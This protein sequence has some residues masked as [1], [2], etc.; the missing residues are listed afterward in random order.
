[1]IPIQQ[2]R[3]GKGGN[4]FQACVAS[5]LEMP[6]SDVPDFCNL[7]PKDWFLQFGSWLKPRGMSA[8]MIKYDDKADLAEVLKDQYVLA[9]GKS[10]VRDI[11]HE[12]VWMNGEVM[13]DPAPEQKGLEGRPDD[14]IVITI[15]NP[16]PIN[17]IHGLQKWVDTHHSDSSHIFFNPHYDT[18]KFLQKEIRRLHTLIEEISK[19]L[20]LTT[21]EESEHGHEDRDP[22]SDREAPADSGGR[23]TEGASQESGG[24]RAED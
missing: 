2:T 16:A 12:V 8:I 14:F 23:S 6:L 10:A 5:L 7:Y 18:E 15:L 9:G 17:K 24:G 1:M 20:S 4:C 19:G 3:T 21:T 11:P 22:G 13:W